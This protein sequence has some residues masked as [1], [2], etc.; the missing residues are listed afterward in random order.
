MG[1]TIFVVSASEHGFCVRVSRD[2]MSLFI[3]VLV[4]PARSE[5]IFRFE[6][7][8]KVLYGLRQQSLAFAQ[9]PISDLSASQQQSEGMVES[10]DVLDADLTLHEQDKNRIF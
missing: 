1:R 5:T 4:R 10:V 8:R 6:L 2:P 9:V 7:K 3:V